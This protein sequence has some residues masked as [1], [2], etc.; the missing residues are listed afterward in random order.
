MSVKGLQLHY[1]VL[2]VMKK[3]REMYLIDGVFY[4]NYIGRLFHVTLDVQEIPELA[5]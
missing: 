4:G 2:P 5:V 1:V 3:L